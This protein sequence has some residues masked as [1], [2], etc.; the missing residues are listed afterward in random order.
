MMSAVRAKNTK[1]ETDIRQR[2]FAKGFRY[3]LHASEL[4]GTPDLVFPKYLTVVFINGCFWHSHDCSRSKV[5]ENR[6]EWWQKKL[7]DNKMRDIRAVQ[8]LLN[9]G[10][11][12][13]IVWECSIRRPG[14]DRDEALNLVC[15]SMEKFLRS[16]RNLLEI[17]G[18]LSKIAREWQMIL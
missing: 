18:P 12:V 2:L 8:K 17:S 10:W 14:I 13:L 11:R 6:R 1:I 7:Q 16:N 3:R 15:V 4:L 5:P 9:D